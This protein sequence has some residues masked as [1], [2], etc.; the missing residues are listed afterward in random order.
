MTYV[1]FDPPFANVYLNGSV[2]R[3]KTYQTD[4]VAVLTAQYC[5]ILKYRSSEGKLLYGFLNMDDMSSAYGVDSQFGYGIDDV[6]RALYEDG[7]R[8]LPAGST[9]LSI[10]EKGPLSES[11]ARSYMPKRRS[12]I[13]K[14][15]REAVYDKFGGRCAYCGCAIEYTEMQVDHIESHYRNMG[16]DGIGNYYPACVDCNGLKSDF[17]VEE[18]RRLIPLCAKS[19]T[20]RQHRIAMKY[21]LITNPKKRIRFYYEEHA[22]ELPTGD[23]R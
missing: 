22:E 13:P 18:F 3:V 5:V 4:E 12:P 1:E 8:R 14:K 2:V 20:G 10:V 16:E 17:G 7:G 11:F 23:I 19:R 15:V 6:W 21:G 9:V